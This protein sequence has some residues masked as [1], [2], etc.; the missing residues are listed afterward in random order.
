VA[1]KNTTGGDVVLVG[2]DGG[3]VDSRE[4][5]DGTNVSPVIKSSLPENGLGEF[6]RGSGSR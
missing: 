4:D 1:K 6:K 2:G 5:D 3:G